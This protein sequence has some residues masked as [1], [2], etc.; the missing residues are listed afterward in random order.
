LDIALATLFNAARNRKGLPLKLPLTGQCQ[1]GQV[2][3]EIR[4]E[5]VAVWACH[6]TECQR[7]SGK[8]CRH[9]RRARHSVLFGFL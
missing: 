2:R 1:C 9:R 4:A 5:P 8:P 7:Q 3:Y 6:C